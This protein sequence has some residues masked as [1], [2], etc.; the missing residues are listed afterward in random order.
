MRLTDQ[1]A[2]L[3]QTLRVENDVISFKTQGASAGRDFAPGLGAQQGFAPAPQRHRHDAPHGGMQAWNIRETFLDEPV[4]VR[5]RIDP[6]QIA[7]DRQVVH[8]VAERGCLDEQD[9]AGRN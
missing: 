5:I 7:D 6:V 4:D 3:D 1:Q 2:A 8:D 9:R